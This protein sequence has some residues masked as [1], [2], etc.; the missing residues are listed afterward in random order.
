[1]NLIKILKILLK[2]W[3]AKTTGWFLVLCLILF[4]CVLFCI[5]KLISPLL[6]EAI[7]S[8]SKPTIITSSAIIWLIGVVIIPIIWLIARKTPKFKKNEIGILFAPHKANGECCSDIIDLFERV[9]IDLPSRVGMTNVICKKLPFNH[10]I[11]SNKDA[12]TFLTKTKAQIIIHGNFETGKLNNKPV[13]GFLD[14]SFTVLDLNLRALKDTEISF[15]LGNIG[16]RQF[17]TSEENSFTDQNVVVNN[18]SDISLYL[19]SISF[20]LSRNLS[21]AIES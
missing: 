17:T 6:Y 13:K 21:K 3:H 12:H 14:I 9:K 19:I 15:I 18:I 4:S 2:Y 7:P 8:I 16:P 11:K 20:I 10:L 5:F 1:M